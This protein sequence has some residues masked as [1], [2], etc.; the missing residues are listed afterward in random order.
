M[1]PPKLP[2]TNP[3]PQ[4]ARPQTARPSAAPVGLGSITGLV[5]GPRVAIGGAQVE[6]ASATFSQT[7]ETGERGGFTFRN[8]PPG[9]YR[10]TVSKPGYKSVTQTYRVAGTNANVGIIRLLPNATII[11]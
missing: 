5:I 3:Y 1:V 7:V 10:V 6:I 11:Q 8:L 4:T 9:L 2:A